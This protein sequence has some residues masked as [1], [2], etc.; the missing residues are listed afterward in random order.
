MMAF[1]AR[2]PYWRAKMS[3][4][5]AVRPGAR[6]LIE[7]ECLTCHAPLGVIEAKANKSLYSRRD[8]DGDPSGLEGVS[9]L[10]C[11]RIGSDR[12]GSRAGLGGH[13]ETTIGPQVFGPYLNP[14]PRPMWRHTGFIP[15]YS[16]H[17]EDP[18]LCGSCHNLYTPVFDE[19]LEVIGEFPEQ[20]VYSEWRVSE[21][22][23]SGQTCQSCH[24]E[25]IPIQT[26][27]AP[28]PPWLPPRTPV[29]N[30]EVVGGNVFML[31]LL[32]GKLPLHAF[33]LSKAAEATR[34]QLENKTL[35]LALSHRVVGEIL[36]VEVKLVNLAGHKFP[37]GYPERRAWIHVRM[38]DASQG[39]FFE[40]GEPDGTAG[41]SFE[42][43]HDVIRS[44]EAVQIYEI[45]PAD[46]NGKP[47]HRLL[48]AAQAVKDNRLLP[49]GFT[50][51]SHELGRDVEVIGDA[52]RD[53]SFSAEEG[54]D[55]VT[56]RARAPA[57][58]EV[59]VEVRVYY[60]SIRPGALD[61]LRGFET[62]EVQAFLDIVD[63]LERLEP[64]VVAF[65]TLTIDSERS[66]HD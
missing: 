28:M 6:N 53:P 33:G 66:A 46:R 36:E 56:Y 21:Y 5:V 9:C 39:V 45:V 31:E 12:F 23:S 16:P 14:F 26:P 27:I 37:T 42:P 41:R 15:A 61:D 60:Q 8:L 4:E 29:W 17:I 20:V 10:V 55:V 49:R 30:H 47:T 59:L 64:E 22:G 7:K 51:E 62:P 1:S 3:V 19:D 25:P 44:E 63:G 52:T 11:H 40:S 57:T 2:D 38:M 43:H 34:M 54:S 50:P 65:E 48:D 35:D 18:G 13:F 24:M 32:E 58:S